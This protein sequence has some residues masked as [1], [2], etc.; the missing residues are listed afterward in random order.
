MSF[1]FE[2][3]L[4]S[5]EHVRASRLISLRRPV[6]KVMVTASVVAAFMGTAAFATEQSFGAYDPTFLLAL[7]WCFP[8]SVGAGLFIGPPVQVRALRQNNRAA[9]GPHV[10]KLTDAGLEMSS[11]G[12]TATLTWANV[13]KVVESREFFLFYFA[14]SWAQVL[15]KRV[16][17]QES[18]PSLRTALTQWVGSKARLM[19]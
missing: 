14:K 3:E 13:V 9:A 8:I 7:G 10:Y 16:V 4:P 17:P 2:F 5:G 1:V 15:P 6:T 18:L 19:G 12:A 11:P